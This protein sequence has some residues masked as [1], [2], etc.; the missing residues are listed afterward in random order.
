LFTQSTTRQI[1]RERER[2]KRE[3]EREKEREKE[4]VSERERAAEEQVCVYGETEI[5]LRG[6]LDMKR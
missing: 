3:R 5:K 2:K 1:E 4:K 6:D